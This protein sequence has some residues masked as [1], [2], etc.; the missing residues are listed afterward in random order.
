MLQISFNDFNVRSMSLW[1]HDI[2]NTEGTRIESVSSLYGFSQL[3]PEPTH[4]THW[5]H[6][7]RST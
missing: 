7:L 4:I 1:V 3:I 6:L 2:K 5:H